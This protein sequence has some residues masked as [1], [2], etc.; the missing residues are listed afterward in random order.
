MSNIFAII[1]QATP[2]DFRGYVYGDILYHPGNSYKDTHNSVVFKPKKV[3]YT[4][5]KS[6][7][8]G[9]RIISSEVAVVVHSQF[10]EFG[11]KVG[12]PVRNIS[13]LTTNSV[14]VLGPSYVTHTPSVD[15]AETDEIRAFASKYAKDIDMFLAPVTGLSNMKRIIYTYVNQTSKAK[16]LAQLDKGFFNWLNTSK[17]STNK[18]AKI[19]NIN[20]Q[21]PKALP[22]I[23]K[24][25]VK[26]MKVKDHIIDQL[27]SANTDVTAFTNGEQGGE[28]YV[29]Q[30]SKIKLVPRTRWQP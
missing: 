5:R 22:A 14:V 6:S 18:Q 23:F 1:E 30:D 12:T 21:M 17:V 7:N 25:V 2:Q 3:T 11:S 24:L 16:N 4:V 8:L 28:G 9:K 19:A 13:A 20:E 15:L 27:D 29:A 10:D 26:V